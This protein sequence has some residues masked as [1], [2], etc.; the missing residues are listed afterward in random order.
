MIDAQ[1]F[2]DAMARLGSAVTVV[3]TDGT[4]G[5][6]G[7]TVSAV[8]SVTDAP[9]SLMVCVHRRS[10]AHAK[11]TENGV[12]CV[13]I[14]SG[15]HQTLCSQFA[16]QGPPDQDR[17]AGA[18][19]TTLE[20]GSPVLTDAVAALDCKIVVSSFIGTHSAFLCEVEA[21]AINNA[22]AGLIYFDRAFHH[23][24]VKEAASAPS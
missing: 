3:T 22:Q 23:L 2:R 18:Q 1:T 19:W 14:L 24:P 15:A 21:I 8:C 5:R 12:L 10:R 17:F 7:L 6:Y 9:P 16:G 13:N 20:T 4:S 11:L